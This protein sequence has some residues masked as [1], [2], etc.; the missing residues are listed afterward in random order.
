[1]GKVSKT[2]QKTLQE[3]LT[4][5]LWSNRGKKM[6]SFTFNN[7]TNKMLQKIS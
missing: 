3:L 5:I 7:E 1:M 4:K 6:E 2:K